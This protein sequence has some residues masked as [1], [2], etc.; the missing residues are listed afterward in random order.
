[1]VPYTGKEL[2]YFDPTLCTNK[3]LPEFDHCVV[4]RLNEPSPG[5]QQNCRWVRRKY[6]PSEIWTLRDIEPGEELL[7]YYGDGYQRNY[8]INRECVFLCEDEVEDAMKQ[9]YRRLTRQNN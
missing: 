4:H 8:E 7:L 5:L 6:Q 1:L 2:Y 3:L 9:Q